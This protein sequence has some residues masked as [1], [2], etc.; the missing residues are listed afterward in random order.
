MLARD[1]Y[2]N[3]A[4]IVGTVPNAVKQRINKMISNEIILRFVLR[5][6]PALLGYEKECILI[7][8]DNHKTVKEQEIINKINLIGE[9]LVYAKQLG[10]S[11]VFVLPFRNEVEGKL[12][13]LSIC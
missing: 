11:L 13:I 3:I 1:P 10:G 6:N 9:I 12:G 4:S 7:V 5:I 2:R 8:K